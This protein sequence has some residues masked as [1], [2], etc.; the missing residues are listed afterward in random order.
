M[1]QKA[2][3]V[4]LSKNST[5]LYI[6]FGGISAGIAMPPFEFYKS[7]KIINENKI[8]IRDFSQCWYQ[9]G[10]AGLSED[11]DSTAT[12]IKLR[13]DNLNPDKIFFVGNSMG[14]YAA[15]LFNK[16]IGVGQSIAFSPQTFI[17]S[18][19]RLKYK[20]NRWEAQINTMHKKCLRKKKVLDLKPILLSSENQNK[21]SIFLSKKNRLDHIHASHIKDING[22][23]IHEFDERSHNI[24]RL[25]RNQGDLPRILSGK[26]GAF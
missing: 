2:I 15:I 21:I 20:D 8:F 18:D 26:W 4:N 1:N 11:I 13:I 6:F 19:L 23:H 24:V 12:E 16:L 5:S 7:A 22:I 17:S 9:D 10:L 25:L 3:E 14:G